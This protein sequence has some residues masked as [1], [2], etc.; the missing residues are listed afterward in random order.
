MPLFLFLVLASLILLFGENFGWTNFLHG[1][2]EQGAK[3]VKLVFYRSAQQ[4]QTTFSFFTFWRSG[5]QKLKHLEERNRELMV[6]AQKV[7]ALT[8]ENKILRDQLE[9]ALPAEWVF[10][11]AQT[12]GRSRYLTID[13]GAEEGVVLGQVAVVKKILVGKVIDV[14]THESQIELPT[15]PESSIPV[16]TVKTGARGILSGQF[17]KGMAIDKVTQGEVLEKEDIVTSTGEGGYLKGLI[18]GKI[19]SVE[20]SESELFQKA[21]VEPVLNFAELEF[22]FLVKS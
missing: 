18:I 3:P 11:P 6:E 5:E 4:V 21:Q 7:K 20:K 9:V 1:V 14:S 22:V 16:Q 13:K 10:D 2:F 19:G 12:I 15:D 17:G 8:E